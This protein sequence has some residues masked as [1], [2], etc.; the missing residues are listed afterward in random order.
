MDAEVKKIF[1]MT[2]DLNVLNHL[3]VN[4][5]SNVPAVLAEAVANS[6]DADA[7]SVTIR[8]NS[9]A[10]TISI[11][12]DGHG[13]SVEDINEKFLRVGYRRRE[14]ENPVTSKFQR[15]VMGRKGI[16]KLSLFSVA[17]VIDVHS[18]IKDQEPIAFSMSL[19]E[20]QEAIRE[21]RTQDT[22]HPPQIEPEMDSMPSGTRIVLR[23]PRKRLNQ[24]PKALRRRLARRFSILGSDY[25]F[26]INLNNEP[27]DIADRDYYR[28]LQYVWYY[29]EYGRKC[30]ELCSNLE[31][32]EEREES[33]FEG[34]IGTVKE[35][36]QLMTEGDSWNKIVVMARGKLV[37]E[38]ILQ[39][40][41][42]TGL[43]SKFIIG[44]ICADNLDEDAHP[45]IVTTN[46]QSVVEDDERNVALC[47]AVKS[48]ITYIKKHWT[49]LRIEVAKEVAF[50][51]N[52]IK[53]WFE[54]LGKD[55]QRRA[56][57]IFGKV[58]RIMVDNPEQRAILFQ[59]SAL[60]FES[61]KA[62]QNLD[63]L[64]DLTGDTIVEFGKVFGHLDDLEATLYHQIVKGRIGVVRALQDLV[65]ENEKERVIQEHLFDHLW[66]LDP[67]WEKVSGS[68]YMEQRLAKEFE[69]ISNSLTDEELRGRVDIKYRTTAGKHVIVELKR[70]S[71]RTDTLT[72]LRQIEIYRNTLKKILSATE[73]DQESI[74]EIICVVGRDLKDWEDHNGRQRSEE[75]L[76]IDGARVVL[77]DQ[78][79][80][81]AYKAYQEFL[82][83]S[84]YVEG[85]ISRL[86]QKIEEDVED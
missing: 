11:C 74:I 63:A 14:Y 37:Q 16:G 28:N 86:L 40:F 62:K 31:H 58:N 10:E 12:D 39:P 71:V 24:T 60:A 45:D 72:L 52:A 51:S 55:D 78:L 57:Q 61:L 64:R 7:T 25:N 21:G 68:E 29:G 48:E 20:I 69:N 36:G 47:E 26:H 3:G 73:N 77:Y 27:I 33:N 17:N 80:N 32:K 18:R 35:S 59:F 41:G 85:R 65:D 53:E 13:M 66:L 2:I 84:T 1:K 34:W 43:Y 54:S 50:K 15:P 81:N 46:R 22:Y 9:H 4:L 75:I 82:E 5:Y 38:D 6:W 44:E 23:K 67:S 19:T 30:V 76:R 49:K 56:E 79:I 70:A 8:I 42:E 83:K